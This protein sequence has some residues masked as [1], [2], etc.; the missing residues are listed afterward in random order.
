MKIDP[1]KTV[2][3][4]AVEL[5]D[6]VPLFERNG[7]DYCHEGTRSLT[8]ACFST[9]L[10][11]MEMVSE[12]E[13]LD[14]GPEPVKDDPSNWKSRPLA[15]LIHY[16]VRK[17]HAY[18]YSQISRIEKMLVEMDT[19]P[20][21]PQEYGPVRWIFLKICRELEAHLR[22]EEE[23]VF[24]FIVQSERALE[25]KGPALR[26]SW[27]PIA[28]TDPV[29]TL[30]FDHGLMSKDWSEIKEKTNFFK[31]PETHRDF[32][33]PL[34]ESLKEL[35]NDNLEHVYLENSFLLKRAIEMGIL[36]D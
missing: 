22:E 24:P 17:H 28:F 20:I 36:K 13:K 5:W 14:Q 30:L 26:H 23:V 10:S 29:R 18:T 15:E 19:H 7:I 1:S 12:L 32:L 27:G 34:Y 6:A 21:L 35:A 31:A 3:R 33:Q 25:K 8:E 4:V 2:G 16:I 11:P 9:G